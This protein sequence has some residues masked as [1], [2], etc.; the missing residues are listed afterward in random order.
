MKIDEENTHI[1]KAGKFFELR[2]YMPDGSRNY[3]HNKS[4]TLEDAILCRSLLDEVMLDESN[5]SIFEVDDYYQLV[6]KAGVNNDDTDV[7][8]HSRKLNL[9]DAIFERSQLLLEY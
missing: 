5:I 3:L 1:V 4:L 2:L 9:N 8:L 6:V 7:R